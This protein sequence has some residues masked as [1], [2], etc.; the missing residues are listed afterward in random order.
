MELN[1]EPFKKWFGFTRRERR[2]SF[3]LLIIII[4]V[5][6]LRTAVP[7]SNIQIEDVTDSLSKYAIRKEAEFFAEEKPTT[8]VKTNTLSGR[9]KRPA[10]VYQKRALINLNSCD[11]SQLVALPGIGQV[12]SVRIIKYRKLLGGFASVEQLTEVYG[13]SAETYE[14]IKGRVFADTSLLIPIKINST[15]Y[16]D[17]LRFPYFEKDEV[18]GIFKYFEL[19]GRVENINDLID[20]NLITTEKAARVKPYLK[21]D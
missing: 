11:T 17:L 12:L 19:K 21:F 20:N 6:A 3:L 9:E 4:S 2:A 16:R 10:T 7:V 14:I 5:F 18:T 15:T 8:G 13:L 1:R